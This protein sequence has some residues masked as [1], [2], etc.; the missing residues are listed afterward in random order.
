ML[1]I[2]NKKSIFYAIKSIIKS[3]QWNSPVQIPNKKVF[4]FDS[5]HPEV[6]RVLIEKDWINS[7]EDLMMTLQRVETWSPIQ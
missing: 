3:Y 2:G 6:L 4:F 1:Y 5:S 7:K